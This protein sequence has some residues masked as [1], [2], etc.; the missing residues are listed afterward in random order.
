MFTGIGLAIVGLVGILIVT[1]IPTGMG[2]LNP[3]A[4]LT[5]P[6]RRCE[7]PSRFDIGYA[8][9]EYR[10]WA[11]P[12]YDLFGYIK[13][14]SPNPLVRAMVGSD[15]WVAFRDK[16]IRATGSFEE[17]ESKYERAAKTNPILTWMGFLKTTEIW[18]SK[19][20]SVR[21]GG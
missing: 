15:K 10:A 11:E 2:P 4:S 3:F 16:A 21:V 1:G 17:V 18:P 20:F 13:A 5:N 12:Q 9:S 14:P 6:T 7:D 19:A 8:K